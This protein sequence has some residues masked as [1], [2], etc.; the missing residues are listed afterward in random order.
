MADAATAPPP[1]IPATGIDAERRLVGQA[2]TLWETLRDGRPFPSRADCTAPRVGA[3][4]PS[5]FL[6]RVSDSEDGDRVVDCGPVLRDALGS[7]PVGQPV[8]RILP[9][10]TERG[11]AFWRVAAELKKP[12]ADIGSFTNAAGSEVLYR[13]VLLPLSDDQQ[14]IDYLL[15]AFSFRLAP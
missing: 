11:L 1:R 13:S 12:I 2:L 10:A 14:R 3:L 8:N 9:S 5:T 15:G 4:A 6:I 7:D